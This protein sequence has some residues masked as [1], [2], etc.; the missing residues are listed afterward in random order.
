[1][2]EL[3]AALNR[4]ISELDDEI[5]ELTASLSRA[6]DRRE[7]YVEM[8]ETEERDTAPTPVPTAPATHPHVL[9]LPAP[10]PIPA[11]E[12]KKKRGRPS[13][14]T[15]VPAKQSVVEESVAPP[16]G[17]S[18]TPEEQARAIARFKPLPR[19]DSSYGG[20]KVG[21]KQ[22]VL[23]TAELSIS[24]KKRGHASISIDEE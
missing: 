10:A 3:V 9:P 4:R 13:K 1:M 8:L 17:G 20:I 7:M 24:T 16:P 22:D 6:Q 2:N 18:T 11:P 12:S 14:V 5:E 15:S 21:S 23:S 19:S